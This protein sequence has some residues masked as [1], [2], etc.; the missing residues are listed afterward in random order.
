MSPVAVSPNGF[1]FLK[2]YVRKSLLSKML[3]DL[4][5][6]RVMIKSSMKGVEDPVRFSSGAVSNVD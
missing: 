5:D 4:L 6:T 1:L 3:S 2:P